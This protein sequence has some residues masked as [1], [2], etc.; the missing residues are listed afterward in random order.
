VDIE[1]F[2]GFHWPAFNL[3]DSCV[4]VATIMLFIVLARHGSHE[5]EHNATPDTHGHCRV[6]VAVACDRLDVF[7][8]QSRIGT[9]SHAH[10]SSVRGSHP[11]QAPARPARRTRGRRDRAFIAAEPQRCSGR[12]LLSVCTRT[13]GAGESNPPTMVEH[14][15]PATLTHLVNALLAGTRIDAE[16]RC[17]PESSTSGTRHVGRHGRR[18]DLRGASWL[19]AQSAAAVHKTFLALYQAES[20][21]W[22]HEGPTAASVHRS[23]CSGGHRTPARTTYEIVSI[24]RLH[25]VRAHPVTG[26]LPIRVQFAFMDIPCRRL[27]LRQPFPRFFGSVPPRHFLHAAAISFAAACQRGA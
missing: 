19:V 8:S 13:R 27:R 14:P 16:R 7:L 10:D 12:V 17:A 24:R 2:P 1:L 26:R 6:S 22:R 5:V 20:S 18:T 4:V 3:A 9:R 25:S 15:A 21:G 11:Q 23:A